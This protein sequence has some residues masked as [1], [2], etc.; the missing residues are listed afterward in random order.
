MKKWISWILAACLLLGLT[1]CGEQPKET[2]TES[3]SEQTSMEESEPVRGS[4][5][6]ETPKVQETDQEQI[7]RAHV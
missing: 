3:E 4:N 7:G 5:I 6:E 1:A 2:V